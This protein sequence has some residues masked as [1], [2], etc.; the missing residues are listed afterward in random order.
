MGTEVHAYLNVTLNRRPV[1]TID[2]PGDYPTALALPDFIV[3]AS[4][5][6]DDPE[7]CTVAVR[8]HQAPDIPRP[9]TTLASA[10]GELDVAID[11]QDWPTVVMLEVAAIDARGQATGRFY[12]VYTERSPRLTQVEAVR[13]SIIDLDD[14]GIL[15]M[16]GTEDQPRQD[17]PAKLIGASSTM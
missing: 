9:P 6:D 13:G 5:S 17:V 8:W 4:C 12:E 3:K 14:A 11:L 2:T 16:T 7:P 15:S 10:V 1:L